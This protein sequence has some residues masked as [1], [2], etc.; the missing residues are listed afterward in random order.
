MVWCARS[1]V[2]CQQKQHVACAVEPCNS[3]TCE[4]I[5]YQQLVHTVLGPDTCTNLVIDLAL[6]AGLV[7]CAWT[8][9]ACDEG[10]T[11]DVL[12]AVKAADLAEVYASAQRGE[13]LQN[14]ADMHAMGVHALA[15]QLE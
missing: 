2:L 14:Q 9:L 3:T 1:A 5:P 10:L 6:I 8:G 13:V 4:K 7:E 11:R 12:A 15:C